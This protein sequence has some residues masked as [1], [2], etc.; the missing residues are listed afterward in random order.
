MTYPY[1]T[2]GA[3]VVGNGLGGLPRRAVATAAAAATDSYKAAIFTGAQ[4]PQTISTLTDGMLINFGGI[5]L[6]LNN[7]CQIVWQKNTTNGVSRAVQEGSDI[8]AL[9]DSWFIRK[10]DDTLTNFSASVRPSSTTNTLD[11]DVASDAIY[12]VGT[13]GGSVT[14]VHKI[15][16]DFSSNLWTRQIAATFHCIFRVIIATSDGGCL[17]G[18][19]TNHDVGSSSVY[20]KACVIKFDASGNQQWSITYPS[21][22]NRFSF[23][24]G[25]VEG[26]DAF[27]ARLGYDTGGG[28]DA[29]LTIAKDG[30][31]TRTL[32]IGT[33][34]EDWD[35]SVNLRNSVSINNGVVAIIN[36]DSTISSSAA[37]IA[38][39]SRGAGSA[40]YNTKTMFQINSLF[41]FT[42]S[43]FG[44]RGVV[45]FRRGFATLGKVPKQ[46]SS[47]YND[48]GYVLLADYARS[49][50]FVLSD[51]Q[52]ITN[53]NASNLIAKQSVSGVFSSSA[54]TTI[55]AQHTISS[56]TLSVVS[57]GSGSS[58]DA[59][60]YSV[61]EVLSS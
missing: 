32:E 21:A 2:K 44:C 56:L 16:K 42:T 17:V 8:Y 47:S 28:W 5:S 51:G 31:S 58:T 15:A 9:M 19:M 6:K 41:P 27:F 3:P 37:N 55:S 45:P 35:Y 12:A 60:T 39:A 14:Y 40:N 10:Y 25:L 49:F 33:G 20:G 11:M 24:G 53:S 54:S 59:T 30:S 4:D 50:S 26:P 46:F 13:N 1:G 29:L 34:L 61:Q 36:A 38:F 18:G 7:D 23:I 43:V 52:S 22:S 57:G 48:K